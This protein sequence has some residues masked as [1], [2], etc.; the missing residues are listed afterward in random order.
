VQELPAG[1]IPLH[2]GK[3]SP[4]EGE[5]GVQV[6]VVPLAVQTSFDAGQAP[7]QTPLAS[8]PQ[9]LTHRAAGPG[10]QLA[11]PVASTHTHTCSHVPLTQWSAVQKFPSLQSTSV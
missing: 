3:V 1:Q 4:Q 5:I 9:G 10:Q 11:A 2:A 8:R 6:Q 7:P